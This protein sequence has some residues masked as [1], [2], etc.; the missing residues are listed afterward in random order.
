MGTDNDSASSGESTPSEEC[1][2]LH[3]FEVMHTI[4]HDTR[5]QVT[6]ALEREILGWIE[7]GNAKKAQE[8][9]HNAQG[10][11]SDEFKR[12]MQ[13][14]VDA[15]LEEGEYQQYVKFCALIGIG[16]HA[17]LLKKAN[18][19]LAGGLVEQGI[20]MY[21]ILR[22]TD[23][24]LCIP[25]AQMTS[26][27]RSLS[28]SDSGEY[29]LLLPLDWYKETPKLAMEW[30]TILIESGNITLAAKYAKKWNVDGLEK[31]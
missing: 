13:Q 4:A 11:W 1:Y 21:E 20:K 7:T 8:L 5:T 23:D 6:A 3:N 30:V 17:S 19:A 10:Q 27:I 12:A 18:A 16:Y 9:I 15:F 28:S 2:G 14:Y 24:S 25:E 29:V 26:V 31:K 22:T